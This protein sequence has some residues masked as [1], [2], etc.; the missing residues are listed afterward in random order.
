MAN[1]AVE[2]FCDWCAIDMADSDGRVR[3]I[4]AAHVEPGKAALVQ[5]LRE[6]FSIHSDAS[7]GVSR[8]LQTGESELIAEFTDELLAESVRD[9]DQ[10]D[11]IRQVGLRSYIGV[12]ITAHG[13]VLGAIVFVAT[14]TGRTYGSAD[15]TVAEDLAHRTAVAVENAQLDDKLREADRR[16]DEFLAMLAHEL[17]NPLAPIQSGLEVLTRTST[18]R[19]ETIAVMQE[20]AGHLVRLVDDNTGAAQMLS[21][22]IGY[23]GQHDVRTVH[24]GRAALD[25]VREWQPD[26]VLLDIGLPGMDGY[27]ICRLIRADATLNSV[28]LVA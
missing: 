3:R 20:Q 17:R 16:K 1:L 8:I 2:Y 15:L 9:K 6:R 22:L 24:E 14:A 27:E 10:L 5:Q 21:L 23:L 25:L 19:P 4:A 26:V 13:N 12:P 18:H 11:L 7:R 28:L